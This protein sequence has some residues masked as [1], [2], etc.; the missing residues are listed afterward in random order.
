MRF[1]IFLLPFWKV[2]HRRVRVWL[3]E[4][5]LVLPSSE[6]EYWGR[7]LKIPPAAVQELWDEAVRRRLLDLWDSL[8]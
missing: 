7:R 3:E 5:A 6:A 8:L 1:S 2:I 4:R